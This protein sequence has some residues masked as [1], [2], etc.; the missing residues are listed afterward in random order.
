MARLIYGCGLRLRE[1][2]NL[3]IKDLDFKR[4]RLTIRSGK[5]DKDRETLL[6]EKLIDDLNS[7]IGMVW[8]LFNQDREKNVPGLYL[9]YALQRK[10]PN[11]GN[12]F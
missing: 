1:C 11:A 8:S 2:L 6:P 4:F 7:H 5:G 3:R 9:P 12:L 10:Y